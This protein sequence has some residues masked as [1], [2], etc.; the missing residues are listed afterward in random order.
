MTFA[1]SSTEAKERR[2]ADRARALS[3]LLTPTRSI[4][5]GT[6]SGG[7]NGAAIEKEAP[8][9]SEAYRRIVA[10][11]ACAFCGVVGHSQAAHPNTGKGMGIKTDDRLC[12]PMCGPR[13]GVQGCHAKL[14]QG[15]LL[16]KEKRRVFELAAGHDTREVI[17]AAG[18]WPAGVPRWE[19]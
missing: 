7:T 2:E 13:P 5:R 11:M 19:E 3:V 17:E 9:R 1:R 6:Y 4:H 18:M 8:V 16:D 10:D 14:D 12:F 15:A